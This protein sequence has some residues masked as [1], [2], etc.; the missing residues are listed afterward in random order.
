VTTNQRHMPVAPEAVWDV[1]ADPYQ[2]AYWVVGS[3]EV[4]DADPGFPAPGTRFHHSVGIGPLTV[5]DH[6]EVVES[7]FP[8]LL[9]LRAK[10]RPL[11]TA[12]V[13]MEITA[14]FGGSTVRLSEQPDGVYAPLK[15]NPLVHLATKL[16]NAESLRRLEELA[17]RRSV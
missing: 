1:L 9:R 16:R 5:R 10:A 15:L 4:R 12:T 17:V 13:V 14:S 6:T 8:R 3:K 7:A 11:G 2:Y